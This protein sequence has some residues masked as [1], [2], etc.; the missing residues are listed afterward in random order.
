MK[1]ATASSLPII[2][3]MSERDAPKQ[4]AL[5]GSAGCFVS[6]PVFGSTTVTNSGF[7]SSILRAGIRLLFDMAESNRGAP[8]KLCSPAPHV[9]VSIPAR[10]MYG[11][12]HASVWMTFPPLSAIRVAR[13][14]HAPVK[15][16]CAVV[17]T[18]QDAYFWTARKKKGGMNYLEGENDCCEGD[19]PKS[20]RGNGL[21]RICDGN[22]ERSQS[23]VPRN[24][25]SR[26]FPTC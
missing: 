22:H 19:C 13:L 18:D 8:A 10:G 11:V 3:Q 6:F 14:T 7:C 5:R 2:M 12:G 16:T 23:M 17:V 26:S 15:T 21:L 25:Q 1:G 20:T 4:R 24:Q 9:L